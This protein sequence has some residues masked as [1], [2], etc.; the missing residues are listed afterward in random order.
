MC[1]YTGEA[2]GSLVIPDGSTISLDAHSTHKV[3][4]ITV[5]GGPS[6]MDCWLKG[7]KTPDP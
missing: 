7:A 5:T 3:S 6:R 1:K 2:Y 4:F